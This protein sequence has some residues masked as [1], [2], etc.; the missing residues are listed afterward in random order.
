[1]STQ[2][3]VKRRIGLAQ[4][5]RLARQQQRQF[6]TTQDFNRRTGFLPGRLSE[7]QRRAERDARG[8]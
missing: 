2:Q 5:E 8:R 1:M 3:E 7:S 6:E 4:M